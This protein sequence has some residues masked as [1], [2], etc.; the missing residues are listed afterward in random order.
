MK[1]SFPNRFRPFRTTIFA[2][3]IIAAGCLLL[4]YRY[5]G[6]PR[7]GYAKAW[8]KEQQGNLEAAADL[9]RKVALRFPDSERAEIA[10]KRFRWIQF[11]GH[12]PATAHRLLEKWLER[13]RMPDFRRIEPDAAWAQ[14]SDIALSPSRG[15]ISVTMSLQTGKTEHSG[16]PRGDLSAQIALLKHFVQ[17]PRIPDTL[18]DQSMLR[19][20]AAAV[21]LGDR[22]E[23]LS[24]LEQWT[25]TPIPD[26]VWR[27]PHFTGP[28]LDDWRLPRIL[29][30]IDHPL[31]STIPPTDLSSRRVDVHIDLDGGPVQGV[32]LT[33]LPSSQ[34]DWPMDYPYDLV[35]EEPNHYRSQPDEYVITGN[36]PGVTLYGPAFSL[37]Q[38]GILC[39]EAAFQDGWPEHG[40]DVELRTDRD[41]NVEV[42]LR[43][44]RK[45]LLKG[46]DPWEMC[47]ADTSSKA[48][49]TWSAGP[50]SQPVEKFEIQI[51]PCLGPDIETGFPPLYTLAFPGEKTEARISEILSEEVLAPCFLLLKMTA[52]GPDG[53][54]LGQSDPL[55]LVWNHSGITHLR[56][57]HLL[58]HQY[59]QAKYLMEKYIALER[60][61]Q[62][63]RVFDHWQE[64][65][66][67]AA[68]SAWTVLADL[69]RIFWLWHFG[70]YEEAGH[71]LRSVIRELPANHPYS[72][73]LR[74][75]RLSIEAQKPARPL[76]EWDTIEELYP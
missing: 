5:L 62:K 59:A 75:V 26:H 31:E 9:Y 73:M 4:Q 24:T 23:F 16:T 56:E 10:I 30:W 27:L 71:M 2:L 49:L 15:G 40:L 37:G 19:L 17:A 29:A 34:P 74:A 47:Q 36:S 6:S 8:Q 45:I 51:T 35:F 11:Q 68:G 54:K 55:P 70:N 32:H 58:Q 44:Y 48:K 3:A 60:G 1:T 53:H 18:Y 14:L 66:L 72:G 13:K 52:L 21:M 22:R 46:L 76:D 28:P 25:A 64:L 7:I 61:D 67:N 65:E 41:D 12:E 50:S 42:F 33:L 69:N 63:E 20:C 57:P 38:L 39:D 43:F